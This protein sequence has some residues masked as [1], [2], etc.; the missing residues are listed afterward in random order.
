MP[1]QQSVKTQSNFAALAEPSREGPLYRQLADHLR[2]GISAGEW[3]VGRAIPSE[4]ELT[5]TTGMS[6]ITVRQAIAELAHEGLLRRD[7][8][9]GTFVVSAG[10]AQEIRGVYSFTD[11]VR[12]QGRTP[13]SRLLERQLTEATDEQATM[14]GLEPGEPVIR[15]MRQRL[16]DGAPVMLDIALV[17]HRRCPV[18]ADADLTG[19]LYAF[20]ADQGVPPLRST[21]IMTAVAASP[22]VA[23]ALEIAP[24]A[25]VSLMNRL[26]VTHGDIPIEWTEEYARPDACRYVMRLV[27]E[28][29]LL[30]LVGAE[31]SPPRP[32][33]W[34]GEAG[35]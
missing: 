25:P 27:A 26:A 30:E 5:R 9:R 29:P 18:L 16:V 1:G 21:D 11:R 17:P 14:L 33:R 19:S 4:R 15:L 24:G 2:R 10:V 12:A 13:S 23:R 3:A 20:L 8:G 34:E 6:R 31:S 32:P 35:G 7:H 22:E 28:G